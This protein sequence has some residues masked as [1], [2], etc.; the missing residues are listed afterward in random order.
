MSINFVTSHPDETKALGRKLAALLTAGDVVVLSGR[1][2]SGK[3]L[4][5]SGVAEGLGIGA[6]ITS[7]TFL[8]AKSYVKGF[9]PLIHA[10]V[11]RLGSVA[12]FDDLGLL[13][14]GADGAVLIEWGEAVAE[15]LPKDRL[16]V[17][18]AMDGDART[19]SFEPVGGWATRDLG[20][21]T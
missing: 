17:S 7:P 20:V 11:Y 6:R 4:F 9:L 3:T 15:A 14:S 10:D 5:V 16:N 18:F 19:I 2:G 12:E 13:D 21:L 1:L 8:I